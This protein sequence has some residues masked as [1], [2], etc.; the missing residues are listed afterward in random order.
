MYVSFVFLEFIVLL[1]LLSSGYC[2]SFSGERKHLESSMW[3][4]YFQAH[5]PFDAHKSLIVVTFSLFPFFLICI[6]RYSFGLSNNNVGL[7]L[8][9]EKSPRANQWRCLTSTRG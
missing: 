6:I 4:F 8:L 1:L 3:L 2:P 7:M 5:Y 9:L